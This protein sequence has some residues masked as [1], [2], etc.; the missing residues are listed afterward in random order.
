MGLKKQAFLNVASYSLTTFLLLAAGA[1]HTG[2]RRWGWK[3]CNK[4]QPYKGAVA[5]LV[6]ALEWIAPCELWI[7]TSRHQGQPID[8]RCGPAVVNRWQL[9]SAECRVAR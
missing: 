3:L 2:V 9:K 6:R 7:P 5:L 8:F 1:Y 4:G